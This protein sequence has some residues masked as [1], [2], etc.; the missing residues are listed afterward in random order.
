M[1]ILCTTD[2]LLLGTPRHKKQVMITTNWADLNRDGRRME[3]I[4]RDME[5]KMKTPNI[6]TGLWFAYMDRLLKCTHEKA[7]IVQIV[8]PVKSV[9]RKAQ[10]LVA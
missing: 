10:K 8:L 6:D 3:R 7:I 9:L 5:T 4:I 1:I 2:A